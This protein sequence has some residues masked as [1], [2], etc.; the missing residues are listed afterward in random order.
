MEQVGKLFM[1]VSIE[2]ELSS[3]RM[4]SDLQYA[5]IGAS[6]PRVGVRVLIVLECGHLVLPASC[7]DSALCYSTRV[8]SESSDGEFSGLTTQANPPAPGGP[9]G[10]PAGHASG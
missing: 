8:A 1:S 6:Q 4:E 10:P 7:D 3:R 9:G 2:N 5:R